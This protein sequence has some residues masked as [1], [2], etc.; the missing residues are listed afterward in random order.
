MENLH[1]NVHIIMTKCKTK[2]ENKIIK[3]KAPS[4]MQTTAQMEFSSNSDSEYSKQQNEECYRRRD[5][6]TY[7]GFAFSYSK[8]ERKL[9]RQS[10]RI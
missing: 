10:W 3:Y 5:I 1:S 8:N 9:S 2:R 4:T 7:K 6:F